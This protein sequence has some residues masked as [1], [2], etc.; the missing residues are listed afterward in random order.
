MLDWLIVGGGLQGVHL[1]IRL[2]AEAGADRELL[3][4]LDPGARLMERWR[5]RSANVG[6]RYLRSPAVHHLDVEPGS[7][8]RFGSLQKQS[9]RELFTRPYARPSLA[10]FDRHCEDLVERHGLE[11]LHRRDEVVGLDAAPET[12]EVQTRGGEAIRSRRVVLATGPLGMPRWPAWAAELCSDAP[13]R[14]HHVLDPTFDLPDP[15]PW[16][17]VV[18]V[19][20]G[21]SGVQTALH[22]S[23][24][25]CDV[26]LFSRH[27]L[28]V[29][30]FD[31]DPGWLGPKRMARF[32]A[33][34]CMQE[35]RR[36]IQAARHRGSVT[37]ETARALRQAVRDRRIELI[38]DEVS[39]AEPS[40]GSVLLE[41]P[42]RRLATDHVLLATGWP[43][44]RP[45]GEWLDAAAERLGLPCAPCGYP[46][47]DRALRWHPGIF[48][49][50]AL[51]ELELGPV[52]RN[53]A[54]A[55]RAGDR[56]V[57]YALQRGRNPGHGRAP[58]SSASARPARRR[59]AGQS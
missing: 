25:G 31:S 7:L 27:P 45:G 57:A 17:R 33:T 48:V 30:Q 39:H 8:E 21:L 34:T 3:R 46:I 51:A 56:L 40:G 1:A 15:P 55:R 5:R 41:T 14:I 35:R 13:G 2:V 4:I 16:G 54:G 28:R 12:C 42:R 32:H 11:S 20:A 37:P 50:G 22:L 9:L 10:L 6:M 19:G 43:F 47:V 26:A 59:L 53:I 38:P 49:T 36:M 52:A 23:A 18:V 24:S 29:H 58:S 44:Q